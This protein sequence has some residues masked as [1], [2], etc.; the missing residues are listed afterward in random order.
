M[1]VGWRSVLRSR[2]A[3]VVATI[4]AILFIAATA[5]FHGRL[6]AW[7][8]GDDSRF[9]AAHIAD[10]RAELARIHAGKVDDGTLK[11]ILEINVQS[12]AGVIS[13]N[14]SPHAAIVGRIIAR[15]LASHTAASL[16]MT[17]ASFVTDAD[18]GGSPAAASHASAPEEE[19]DRTY[20]GQK[21][22]EGCHQQEAGNWAHTIH[23]AVFTLNPRDEIEA[24]GC[25]ACHGP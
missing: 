13:T 23:A 12:A 17:K 5:L 1:K 3:A 14:P 21:T 2:T 4:A 6:Y 11:R 24:K 8:R 18:A 25:E 16:E 20:V 10:M 19:S 22:C 15:Y 9:L 7:S